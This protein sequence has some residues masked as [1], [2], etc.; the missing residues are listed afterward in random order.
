M[1]G[2]YEEFL[3]L[4]HVA[5]STS[6]TYV[7]Q[8]GNAFAYLTHS[9]SPWILDYGASNHLYGNKDLFSS[10]TITSPLLMITLANGTQTMAKGIG[11]ACPLPSLPLTY[12]LYVHVSP[13]NIIYVSKLIHDHTLLRLVRM[14]GWIVL[15]LVWL[16]R[17]IL[18]YMGLITMTLS[19]L[20][21]RWLSFVFFYL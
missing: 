7:A 16:P 13:F 12:I 3:R 19:L 4:T 17:C 8:T 21:P 2:E 11:S 6:I 10:F 14:V 1:L 18:R 9:L 15:R 5:K 20:F